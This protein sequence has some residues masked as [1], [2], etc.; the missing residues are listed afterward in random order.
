MTVV[1]ANA[2]D[3]PNTEPELLGEG[4]LF[5]RDVADGILFEPEQIELERAV[6]P[7]VRTHALRQRDPN[8]WLAMLDRCGAHPERLLVTDHVELLEATTAGDL[9]QLARKYLKLGDA[10]EFR[11]LPE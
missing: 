2:T 3:L 5:L 11:Y 8:Y 4:F 9:N 1:P 10:C 6:R 7:M